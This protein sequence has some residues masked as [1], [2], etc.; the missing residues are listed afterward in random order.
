M[1]EEISFYKQ[2]TKKSLL[3]RYT[4]YKPPLKSLLYF[5]TRLPRKRIIGLNFVLKLDFLGYGV[6]V[7]KV[8]C[9]QWACFPYPKKHYSLN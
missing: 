4:V 6:V 5:S 2:V 1:K 3:L 7:R 9:A 8:I